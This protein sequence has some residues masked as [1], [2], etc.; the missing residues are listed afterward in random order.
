MA[1][2][3]IPRGEV[4]DVP[5]LEPPFPVVEPNM[6]AFLREGRL[7]ADVNITVIVNIPNRCRVKGLG[8]LECQRGIRASREM[9]LYPER[10][11]N[12]TP[13]RIHEHDPVRP[14]IGVEVGDGQRWSERRPEIRPRDSAFEATLCPEE[15]GA[16]SH[17]NGKGKLGP[18][19]HPRW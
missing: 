18:P 14:A 10:V 5:R 2:R 9:K 19:H 3:P 15:G 8:R 12:T 7:D 16:Q 1:R 4:L 6:K 11:L 13:A 17:R